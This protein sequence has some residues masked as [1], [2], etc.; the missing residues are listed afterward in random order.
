[1]GLSEWADE[2]CDS[3]VSV[4]D[5]SEDTA[6]LVGSQ[7]AIGRAAARPVPPREHGVATATGGPGREA[8]EETLSRRRQIRHDIRHELG[9]IMLLAS[10]LA[11]ASDVGP[12]SRRRAG[13]ILREARWLDHLQLAY[14]DTFSEHDELNQS[15]PEL[16]RLDRLAG[17]AVDAIGL[18]SSTR[19]GFTGSEV[20]TY[21]NRLAFWRVLRNMV[22]NAV[23]AAGPNGRVDVR[24]GRVASW[25]IAQVDDDGPGFGAVPPGAESLGLEIL[26]QFAAAWNGHLEIC[27]SKLGGCSVRLRVRAASPGGS[28]LEL[29]EV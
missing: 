5:M 14:D 19:I 11:G 22:G 4:G 7:Q 23:R 2:L 13:Q 18:S 25:A 20:W 15:V 9:T 16:I 26:R 10:L 27:R 3:S 8:G 21:A 17:E 6:R 28:S 24:V 12:E 1:M 29:S